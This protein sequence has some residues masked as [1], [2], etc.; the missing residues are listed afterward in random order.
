MKR[1]KDVFPRKGFCLL[2][3]FFF[4]FAATA[5]IVVV[6]VAHNYALEPYSSRQLF[7]LFCV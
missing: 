3:T 7:H 1:E 2:H 5:A 6:A 4:L